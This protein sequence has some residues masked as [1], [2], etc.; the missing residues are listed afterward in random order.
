MKNGVG[1][2]W[3]HIRAFFRLDAKRKQ[4]LLRA[5]LHHMKSG[6]VSEQSVG[7]KNVHMFTKRV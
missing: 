2:L 1:D 7:T 5:L 3:H 4:A 6:L